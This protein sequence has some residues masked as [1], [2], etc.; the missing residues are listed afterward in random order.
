MAATP[1][2]PDR[3]AARPKAAYSSGA[4]RPQAAP[5]HEVTPIL[6]Q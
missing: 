4:P 5:A 2:G 3:R 1:V 6:W